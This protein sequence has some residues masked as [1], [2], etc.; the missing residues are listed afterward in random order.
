MR[1]GAMVRGS[2]VRVAL[3]LGVIALIGSACGFS[4]L[5]ASPLDAVIAA[6]MT[7]QQQRTASINLSETVMGPGLSPVT[8]SSSGVVD[9]SDGSMELIASVPGSALSGSFA[10]KVLVVGGSA[11][12][13]FPQLSSILHRKVWIS[14]PVSLPSVKGGSG[15]GFDAGGPASI[16]RLLR[17]KGMHAVSLGKKIVNGAEC[18]GYS[19][20]LNPSRALLE[21]R[22]QHSKLPHAISSLAVQLYANAHLHVT[23]WVDGSQN[24]RQFTFTFTKLHL[25][26][27][28]KAA[29][30]MEFSETLNFSHFGVPVHLTAPPPSEVMSFG[31]FA[32]SLRLVL[33]GM[34][35]QN[36]R[37]LGLPGSAA[38]A[39]AA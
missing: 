6:A 30:G 7:T 39:S 35:G 1:M 22:L 14:E 17:S 3:A 20:S 5:Q 10:F 37:A 38:S 31:A 15:A 4:L 13:S 9:L 26:R 27:A 23:I 18:T 24:I 33:P 34:H 21:K 16:L 11:Y 19:V 8:I 29:M 36:P 2:S 32:N 28:T 12:M 25:P